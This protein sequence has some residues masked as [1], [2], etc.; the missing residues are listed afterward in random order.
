MTPD[1]R[2]LACDILITAAETP[3]G[4]WFRT[5]RYRWYDPHLEG[6]TA[7]PGPD[8]GPNV[9]WRVVVDNPEEEGTRARD[10]TPGTIARV[11]DLL[12]GDAHVD[13]PDHLIL[14]FAEMWEAPLEADFDAED[15]D[16]L[17]QLAVFGEVVYG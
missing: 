2:Q 5:A 14:R 3:A 4:D 13:L 17:V 7:P 11:M 16:I 15:A 9:E 10:L 12:Q 6:G 8:G 1:Q